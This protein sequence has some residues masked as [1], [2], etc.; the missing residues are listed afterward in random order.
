M[1]LDDGKR[2]AEPSTRARPKISK[3][4]YFKED[5]T[6]MMHGFGDDPAPLAESVDLVEDMLLEYFSDVL[7]AASRISIDK[8]K[9]IRHTD[10]LFVI[11]KDR[12]KVERAKKLLETYRDVVAIRKGNT[13][14][15]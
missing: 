14:D 2:E 11:R 7:N 3:K 4:R 5:L 12:P 15:R 13:A 6:T 10:L 8:K 1:L 9:K